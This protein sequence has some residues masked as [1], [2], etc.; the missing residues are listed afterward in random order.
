MNRIK[1]A[2]IAGKMVGGGVESILMSINK[3]I[4]KNKFEVDLLVDEDSKNRPGKRN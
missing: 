4:D 3:Y 2:L 1:V